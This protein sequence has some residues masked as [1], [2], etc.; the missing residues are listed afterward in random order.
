M[1]LHAC[2]S[3]Y[4]PPSRLRLVGMVLS[5]TGLCMHVHACTCAYLPPS[6][7]RLVGMVLSC[8]VLCMQ[9]LTRAAG[10]AGK[11]RARQSAKLSKSTRR[12][13]RFFY[14]TI[15]PWEE[16]GEAL[17]RWYD[18]VHSS[19]EL[20]ADFMARFCFVPR[21]QQIDRSSC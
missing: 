2:T 5:C 6:R 1:W 10:D 8:T 7:L 18:I 4:L 21:K 14:D 3:A 13:L 19:A 9:P 17:E 11:K 20:E 16:S 15:G 12:A